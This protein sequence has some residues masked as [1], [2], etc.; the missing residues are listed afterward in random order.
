[1]QD[2]GVCQTLTF[3]GAFSEASGENPQMA[4]EKHSATADS[5]NVAQSKRRTRTVIFRV[6]QQEHNFLRTEC[7]GA[8]V[9]SLSEYARSELLGRGRTSPAE[10]LSERLSHIEQKLAELCQSTNEILNFVRA[11]A[12]G[13]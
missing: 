1:V 13:S 3:Y 11:S 6:T 5:D 2:T 4:A 10:A 7:E 9:R 12:Q 8:G